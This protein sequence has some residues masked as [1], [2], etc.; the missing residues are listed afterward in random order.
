MMLIRRSTEALRPALLYTT[1]GR[2]YEVPI[3]VDVSTPHAATSFST[4]NCPPHPEERQSAG[5]HM[6]TMFW[7]LGPS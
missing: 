6:S 2:R 1:N 4:I 5:G 3:A 7:M